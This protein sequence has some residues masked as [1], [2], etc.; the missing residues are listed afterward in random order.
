MR[1][2]NAL[3]LLVTTGL[4]AAVIPSVAF[5]APTASLTNGYGMVLAGQAKCIE[6]HSAA[7]GGIDYDQTL[8]G[9]HV[10]QGLPATPPSA[11]TQFAGSGSVSASGAPNPG[12][13][14]RWFSAGGT[15][16]I[17]GLTWMTMFDYEGES[18]WSEEQ[19]SLMF[20]S[21]SPSTS[22]V[23]PWNRVSSLGLS[24]V[25]PYYEYLMGTS[26]LSD[27]PVS[28]SC[29]MVNC[30]FTGGTQPLA[31]GQTTWTIPNPAVATQPT[32]QTPTQWARK[33]A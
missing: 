32:S 20:F 7:G 16:S 26:A 1:T 10:T 22:T 9:R 12:S 13:G 33:T 27:S 6:C 28:S 21:G 3:V 2:R 4:V 15:Y 25:S 19:G 31:S 8:H 17:A 18:R 30:H 24:H 5:G 29:G 23:S 14:L 11:W